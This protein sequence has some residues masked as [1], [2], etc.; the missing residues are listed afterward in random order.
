MASVFVDHVDIDVFSR[1]STVLIPES[2]DGTFELALHNGTHTY[3][4]A[5]ARINTY[6]HT[7][8]NIC[9]HTYTTWLFKQQQI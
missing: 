7:H 9:T 3:A 4:H 8:A 6:D 2:I 5:H 1:D